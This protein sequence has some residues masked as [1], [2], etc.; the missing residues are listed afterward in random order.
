[1]PL[2]FSAPLGQLL[3]HILQLPHLDLMILSCFF[4][5]I[6]T[7]EE[8]KN[9]ISISKLKKI[10]PEKYLLYENAEIKRCEMLCIYLL[11][12]NINFITIYD[13]ICFLL[14]N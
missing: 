1:M 4:L 10:Y 2:S 12:Y 11:K 5:G 6:K 13:C 9:M 14:I 3:I 7:I 8:Q